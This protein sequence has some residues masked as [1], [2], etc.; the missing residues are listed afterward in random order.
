MLKIKKDNGYWHIAGTFMGERV[1]RTTGLRAT[2]GMKSLAEKLRVAAEK[3]IADGKYGPVKTHETWRDA[4]HA[5]RAWKMMEKRWTVRQER[6]LDKMCDFWGDVRLTE[7]DQ[8]AINAYVMLTWGHLE[9]GTIRR[10]LNDF[11]AVLSYADERLEEYKSPKIKRPV[12]DDAR[13]IHLE[14]SEANELLDWIAAERPEYHPHLVTLVDTGLR[15]GEMMRL[16]P[17]SFRD[18]DHLLVVKRTHGKTKTITR[19]IPYT[20]AMRVLANR[21]RAMP[22]GATLYPSKLGG[23]WSGDNAASATLNTA[24]KQGCKAIGL[25]YEGEEKIRVHDLRHTFAYLT[26]KA[27][28][29]LGDLQLLLGH[30]DISMTMRYRGFISSRATTYVSNLRGGNQLSTASL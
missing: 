8:A 16:K 9:P 1:R 21:F 26:A 17:K 20:P 24:L 28:A 27:G 10:Y 18:E 25:P 14:E 2:Q 15:L 30:S 22:S 5:Y 13:D 7:I 11:L 12:A 29:D 3:D 23:A 6:K 4:Y 19:Q